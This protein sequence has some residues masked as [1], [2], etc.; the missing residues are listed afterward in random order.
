MSFP[1]KFQEYTTRIAG[2]KRLGS[3]ALAELALNALAALADETDMHILL[4]RAVGLV[5][6]LRPSMPLIGRVA[7]EALYRYQ[8][9][10][11]KAG[12]ADYGRILLRAVDEVRREYHLMV[13][14]IV[15][16]AQK[17]IADKRRVATISYSGTVKQVLTS[18]KWSGSVVIL[19][20]RPMREGFMLAEELSSVRRVEVMVD[21][22]MSY[23]VADADAIL[24]GADAVFRKGGFIGKIGCYPLCT[25]AQKAG[26]PVYVLADTWKFSDRLDIALEEGDPEEVWPEAGSSIK[27]RNPYFEVTPHELVTAYVTEHGVVGSDSLV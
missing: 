2:E 8:E 21:A 1:A 18:P 15:E 6:N 22:A 19:E 24:V 7:E 27:I 26:K 9:L 13:E 12:D 3:S 17:L 11:E 10:V 25:L 16:N 5:R 4:E 20:S 14:Q 23:A